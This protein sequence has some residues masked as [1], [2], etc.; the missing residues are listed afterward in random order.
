MILSA[1]LRCEARD[2]ETAV[3]P[4][5]LDDAINLA[6]AQSVDAAVALNQLKS[7]YWHYRTYRAELLPEVNFSATIPNYRK[8]YSAYQLDDGSY[9][10]VRNNYMQMSGEVSINQNIWLTGGTLSLNTSLDYLKMLEG[11]KYKRFMTVPVALTFNQPIFGVNTV[12]WDRRIEP[13]RYEEAKANFISASEGVA[14]T[15]INYFFNLLMAKETVN[16]ARQNMENAEKL[17]EVAVAKRKMGQIS[18]NDLLQL[19]L[20]KLNARSELTD[21]ESNL[22]SNMFQLRSFLGIEEDVDLEPVVPGEDQQ[23]FLKEHTPP[24]AGSRLLGGSSQR[25]SSPD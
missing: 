4:I 12:K 5:T 1:I 22:K 11:D 13:V 16:I 20:N 10:F 7:A 9:T 23:C 3:R 15:T 6:R 19:E 21:G 24:S 14:M 18:E 2:G 8:S 17:Y 25:Q